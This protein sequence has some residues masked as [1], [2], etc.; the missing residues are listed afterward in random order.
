MNAMHK[1]SVRQEAG[2]QSAFAILTFGISVEVKP[3]PDI[4]NNVG[5]VKSFLNKLLHALQRV[6]L[7]A[8]MT[9]RLTTTARS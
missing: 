8:S 5:P 7:F 4:S 6:V 3:L 9:S 1:L 2:G